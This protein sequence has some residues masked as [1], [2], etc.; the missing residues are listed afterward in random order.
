MAPSWG[1]IE[2]GAVNS[3]SIQNIPSDNLFRAGGI[4]SLRGYGYRS[5]GLNVNNSIVGE[6]FL[7]IGSLEYQ[8]RITDMVSLDVFYDYGNVTN[9]WRDIDP[10]SGYG[11]GVQLR[12]PVGPVKLDIA[13]GQAIHRYRLHFSIGFTF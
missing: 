9:A 13:Y 11:A 8:H 5:L 6:R 3:H 10:V 4:G 12:T 2:F 7:A 1:R